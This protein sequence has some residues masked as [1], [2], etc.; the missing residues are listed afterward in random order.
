MAGADR[1]RL[2]GTQY[3]GVSC[4]FT[5]TTDAGNT[6]A[7]LEG[8]MGSGYEEKRTRPLVWGSRRDGRPIGKGA[9]KY[10]PGMLTIDTEE[11]TWD[12]VTDQLALEASDNES[13]GDVGFTVQVQLFEEDKPTTTITMT[14]DGCNV[15]G[16][17]GDYPTSG[18]DLLKKALS[19]S[20]L[21][22]DTG[23]KTLYSQTR[24]S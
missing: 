14:F 21:G 1:S 22:K 23:G 12:Y 20:Y 4:L 5:I 17:K 7:N 24:T 11:A 2:Q 16:E 13:F 8:V 15:D 3:T 18:G 10:E 19:F 9:G 6:L